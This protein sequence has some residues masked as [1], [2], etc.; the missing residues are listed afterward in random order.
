MNIRKYSYAVIFI[1]AALYACNNDDDGDDAAAVVPP[2]DLAEQQADEIEVIEN[3]L[4]THFYTLVDNPANPDYKIALFDTIA[5]EN[6]GRQPLSLSDSLETKTITRNDVE[7]TLHI[8]NLRKG[9]PGERQP[10][11][12]DSTLVTYRGELFYDNQDRDG[13]G[14]P[15][16]ADI[17]SKE[18][19]SDFGDDETPV[20]RPDADGDGIADDSDVDNPDLA[21]QPDSD[22]DGIIDDKDPVD[23]N[24]PNRRVFDNRDVPLWFDQV[25]IEVL[26]WRET[27][28]DYKGASG[29][30]EREDGTVDY[31]DDF[32]SFVVFIPSG[33]AYFASPPGGSGIP[34]YSPLIFNIQL[35]AVNEADH[36]R[37]GI[38]SYLEDLDN[39]RNVLD[40]DDNT[41][42]DNAANYQDSDDDNDGTLTRDEITLVAGAMDDGIV[43]LDEIT[44]YDDDGDGVPNHLDSDDR[45]SK[46]E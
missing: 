2:R 3:Y 25:G 17:D 41:D 19:G 13:D 20:T 35:Y 12:A 18:D 16:L 32:G 5:G 33:L 31:N 42:G 21:G 40:A 44:F 8:L 4:S 37:D 46:N 15:N 39:D 9:A 11:F 22:G 6:S 30:L 38:P 27:L 23:N 14:I 28:V 24:N 45:D 10:T 7:Y 1:M 36:D 26:G 29:F 34:R 43:T